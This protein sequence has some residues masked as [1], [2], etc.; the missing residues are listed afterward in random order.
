VVRQVL[1]PYR[2]PELDSLWLAGFLD[3]A[4]RVKLKAMKE[5]VQAQGGA[6]PVEGERERS[7]QK[8]VI[9]W[10]SSVWGSRWMIMIIV[11]LLRLHFTEGVDLHQ[12]FHDVTEARPVCDSA[13]GF[14]MT[15]GHDLIL[16]C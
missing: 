13:L 1:P 14:V 12:G 10:R 5:L 15:D 11:L 2:K 16:I 7:H 6:A 4:Q 8:Y 9:R 3:Q